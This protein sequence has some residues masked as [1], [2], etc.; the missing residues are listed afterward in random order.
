MLTLCW[1]GGLLFAAWDYNLSDRDCTDAETIL[2]LIDQGG[3][4]WGLGKFL[5]I[6]DDATDEIVYLGFGAKRLTET[7]CVQL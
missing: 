5:A 7:R 4:T 1:F 6:S 2:N 3:D